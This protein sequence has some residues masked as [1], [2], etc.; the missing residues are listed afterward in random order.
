M[1][2][3][4]KKLCNHQL[5]DGTTC[6]AYKALLGKCHQHQTIY[7]Y[8]RRKIKPYKQ[9]IIIK[10]YFTNDDITKIKEFIKKLKQKEINI[11]S[12]TQ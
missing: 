8:K 3:D 2:R 4:T 9:T 10:D 1:I 6:R 11:Y 7:D 5:K 12:S